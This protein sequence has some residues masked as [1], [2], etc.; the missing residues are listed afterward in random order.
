MS[1]TLEQVVPWGRS[2]D[3]YRRMFRLG[4]P[5]ETGLVLGCGDGPASFNAEWKAAGGRA[6]SCDPI[7][8]F[9]R[10]DIERRFGETRPV[11]MAQTR[12]HQ[13]QFVWEYFATPDELEAAR[14]AAATRFFGDFESG[15][16]EGRYVAASLPQLPF[17]DRQFNLALCS[18]FLFLYSDHL[19]LE[20][21]LASLRE[22]LRVARE[23]RVFPLLGLDAEPSPHLAT[24]QA[25]LAVECTL[26]NER[27][28][29]EFQ[30]GGHSMLRLV[31]LSHT[32]AFAPQGNLSA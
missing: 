12:G 16:V 13:E 10:A 20:F 4:E 32:D 2:L 3:E 17:P 28:D 26:S 1:F 31:S 29:Y 27:V 19:D 22:L 9:S 21:H 8:Q 6:V 24:V 15:K 30:R 25:A 18:H 5:S 14:V 23:V 7:Y 11:I